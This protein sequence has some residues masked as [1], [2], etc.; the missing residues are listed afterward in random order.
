MDFGPFGATPPWPCPQ[1]L[2][3]YSGCVP[4]VLI[5]RFRKFR[6]SSLNGL[7]AMVW[8]YRQTYS[9]PDGWVVTQ[10]PAFSSKSTGIIINIQEVPDQTMWIH[11]LSPLCSHIKAITSDKIST[12]IHILY[13]SIKNIYFRYSLEV[14]WWGA[15]NEYLQQMLWRNKKKIVLG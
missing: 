2:Y 1:G 3:Q 9:W 8:H 15:S 12:Q 14:P 4:P 7:G 13:F 5:H 10:Y 11:Y 6:D